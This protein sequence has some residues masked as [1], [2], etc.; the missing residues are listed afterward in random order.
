[1]LRSRKILLL[2]VVIFLLAKGK[3]EA[4]EFG[5][6]KPNYE[7]F[8]FKVHRTP[9]FELYHYLQNDSLVETFSA[10]GERWYLA[11]Q[12]IFR[13]TFPKRNPIILYA[14]HA[15]FW[16]TNAILGSVGI[17]TGGV[18]E[19]L[20]NRVVMPVMELNSQTNHVLGHELVHAFQ[21]KM[22]QNKKDSLSI[23]NVQNLPLWMVEGLA[24]FLSIGNVDSHTAMWMRD[25][26]RQNKFPTLKDMTR[27]S[28]Y[29]PYRYGQAFWAFMT[30][31]FGD[32]IVYPLFR[33]SAILGYDKAIK[34]LTG[35]DEKAFS[36]AWR[37]NLIEHYGKFHELKKDSMAG[38]LLIGKK[39]GKINIAPVI[40]PNG[41]YVAFLSEKNIFSIDLFLADARTGEV[42]KTLS[43]TARE[44]HIDD[45]SFIES[46]GTW[47]PHSDRFAFVAFSQGNSVLSVVDMNAKNTTTTINIPGLPYFS[48]PSWSPDGEHIVLSGMVNGQSD[49]YLYHLKSKKLTQLTHDWYSDIQPQWS[50]DGQFIAFVSDRPAKGK[51][52]KSKALQLCLLDIKQ[53]DITVL[54]IFHGAENLNPVFSLNGKSL[55]FL[56]NRD[57]FR[58]LY[59]YTFE[60]GKLYQLTDYL[61][62]ISGITAYSPAL[63]VSAQTGDVAYT[64]YSN[65]SYTIYKAAPEEFL[66]RAVDPAAVDFSAAILPPKNR[67]DAK[68]AT[69]Y[70]EFTHATKNIKGGDS[71]YKSKLGLEY[72]GNQATVGISTSAFGSHTGMA[73]GVDML[74]GDMLGHQRLFATVGLNGEIYDFGGQLTYLNQ[75][76]RINWGLSASHIP[77]RYTATGYK[78]DTVFTKE[79][80]MIPTTNFVVDVFRVFGNSISGFVYF[81]FSTTRRIEVGSGYSFYSYRLERFNNH[82]YGGYKIREKREKLDAPD[83]YR[84][85]NTYAAYV[86]D[87]SYFGIASPMRG[88]RYRIEIDETYDALNYHTVTLDFRQY[89]FLNPTAFAFRIMHLARY[90]R[91]AE[92]SRLYPLSF[93]YPTLT[94]GN[95]LDN[96]EG[97][98]TEEGQQYSINQVFGSKIL[99]ANA[100]WRLPLT[101]PEQLAV[102]KSKFFFTELAL[103][104]DAGLAWTSNE[105]P[106]LEWNAASLNNNRIPFLSAGI[107]LR[108]NLFGMLVVEP[109]YAYP[110]RGNGFAKAV[111]GI[112]ISPG[113]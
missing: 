2:V 67:A 101:G 48:N 81:P 8:D 47:S 96:T 54:D 65:S 36:E 21:Y 23:N 77:Y 72:L 74:F 58:N 53:K 95:N 50:S 93:A 4:Q 111:F 3:G 90:G 11:H 75:K 35:L 30:G 92:S 109:Y 34:E 31:V 88:R 66:M 44:S 106:K 1:M 108:V 59:R 91:D 80:T 20:R 94:R 40:S 25:A 38:K 55:Y 98:S 104:A 41:N 69:S 60:S 10:A 62:G 113:W 105:K 39:A 57:G 26:L 82:Y 70:V 5:R 49:I 71:A 18:T 7:N 76:K 6:N 32:T 12:K 85:G 102:I 42:I 24:E 14:N 61:T 86:F 83:G 103:F 73:G 89:A 9:N 19:A 52:F 29:F 68:S 63:S 43:S 64:Y 45:F 100:E 78:S 112:N 17:G 37:R 13:D 33:K 15:D 99:V 110:W 107:S 22:F 16:Q 28:E 79:G 27:K 46:T 87:N 56:S 51:M 84:L 97:Y